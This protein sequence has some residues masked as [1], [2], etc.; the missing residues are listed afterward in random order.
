MATMD[1][2]LSSNSNPSDQFLLFPQLA[3]ELRFHI[4]ELA[5]PP[6]R[7]VDVFACYCVVHDLYSFR[8][9][10]KPPV[11]LQV[12]AEARLFALN[13]YNLAFSCSPL[14]I[15]PKY[16]NFLKDS[17]HISVDKLNNMILSRRETP[18]DPDYPELLED[19]QK[20]KPLQIGNGLYWWNG[21]TEAN[22]RELFNMFP[23]LEELVIGYG[24]WYPPAQMREA[25]RY[26]IGDT[27]HTALTKQW[28]SYTIEVELI[29]DNDCHRIL[30]IVKL[31]ANWARGRSVCNP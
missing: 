24:P 26:P 10:N 9:C 1:Q 22:I 21:E 17:L 11:H 23:V 20:V 7:V 31:K 15:Q 5:L 13:T 27:L 4:W 8:T 6:P 2:T 28:V 12:N 14:R 3:A 25:G 30:K 19:F 18:Q 29:H 16:F